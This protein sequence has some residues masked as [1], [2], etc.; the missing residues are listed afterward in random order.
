MNS[1]IDSILEALLSWVKSGLNDLWSLL[2]GGSD[3]FFAW[4]GRH[5][6]SLLCVLLIGG[7]T[8]DFIVYLLR[9]HPQRVWNSK[10]NRL[11]LRKSE[12]DTHFEEGYNEGIQSFELDADPLISDYINAA[13]QLAT[14]EA[15]V[16]AVPMQPDNQD[17][18][19]VRR[20]RSDRHQHPARRHLIPIK[21]PHLED[22]A[23]NKNAS[24]ASPLH[25]REAF[26]SPVYPSDWHQ[27][28]DHANK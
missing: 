25:T 6:L 19:P 8:I 28:N 23:P 24:I 18:H 9:W 12:E 15:A 13:P 3:S 10:L 16:P 20:R 27:N 14:Y 5:W 1:F 4:L 17:Q 22:S 26:H 11:F 21:L 2:S 7:L